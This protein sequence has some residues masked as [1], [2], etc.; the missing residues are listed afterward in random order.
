VIRATHTDHD[1]L[2]VRAGSRSTQRTRGRR[3]LAE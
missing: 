2:L 1:L 3:D